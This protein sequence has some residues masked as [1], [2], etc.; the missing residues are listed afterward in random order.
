M[1]YASRVAVVAARANRPMRSEVRFFRRACE[2]RVPSN[3]AIH[4]GR[5]MSRY[6]ASSSSSRAKSKPT[7]DWIAVSSASCSAVVGEAGRVEVAVDDR[8]LEVV[9]RVGDVVRE[10]HDLRLDAAHAARCVRAQPA[11]D[12]LVVGVD[13]ELQPS[14]GI[15]KRVIGRP[16]VL[17][18]RVE[19]RAG[20]VQSV[21]AARRRRRPSARAAS[22]S[23]A[24]A[25]CPRTRRCP[26][27]SR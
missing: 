23:A 12:V 17:A 6:S 25:R 1:A 3:E 18:R 14:A 22:G 9:H 21:A 4:S 16:R 11:E 24:S 20:Q 10:V 5:R 27:P 15:G 13:A 8:V 26:R 2:A 19:A 7:Q